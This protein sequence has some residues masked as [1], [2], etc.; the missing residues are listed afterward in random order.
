MTRRK[1]TMQNN[2]K[3]FI[4]K[5][6]DFKA[7]VLLNIMGW[8]EDLGEF[9]KDFIVD[10]AETEEEAKKQYDAYVAEGYVQRDENRFGRG[11]E[12]TG[13]ISCFVPKNN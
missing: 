5:H 8:E 12:I 2:I 1:G 4:T 3:N 10:V 9:G 7:M 13:I 6:P 11:F